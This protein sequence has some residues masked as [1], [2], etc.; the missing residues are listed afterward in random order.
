M[1]HHENADSAV[2]DLQNRSFEDNENLF[3][4]NF[5]LNYGSFFC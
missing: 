1:S 4:N 2:I 5:K 3:N